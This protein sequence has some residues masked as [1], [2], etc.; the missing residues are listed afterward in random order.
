M[1]QLIFELGIRKDK[2]QGLDGS[3]NKDELNIE[4]NK[5]QNEERDEEQERL[6]LNL[7]NI[8][9]GADQIA[10]D[11]E[12]AKQLQRAQDDEIFGDADINEGG[13]GQRRAAAKQGNLMR[14]MNTITIDDEDDEYQD[15]DEDDDKRK[16]KQNKGQKKG[17]QTITPKKKKKQGVLSLVSKQQAQQQPQKKRG[18]KKKVIEDKLQ[19]ELDMRK[20]IK[21]DVNRKGK[22]GYVDD[23]LKEDHQQEQ[24]DIKD[25]TQDQIYKDAELAIQ[26]SQQLNQQETIQIDEQSNEEKGKGRNVGRGK[27]QTPNRNENVNKKKKKKKKRNKSDQFDILDDDEDIESFIDDREQDDSFNSTRVNV[28]SDDN[29][30]IVAV[31]EIAAVDQKEQEQ[32]EL[33]CEYNNKQQQKK[34][35]KVQHESEEEDY[36]YLNQGED[37]DEYEQDKKK[38]KKK[39]TQKDEKDG[40]GQRKLS[41]ARKKKKKKNEDDAFI[42]NDEVS[43][44]INY[45]DFDEQKRILKEQQG[46]QINNMSIFEDEVESI[47]DDDDQFGIPNPDLNLKLSKRCQMQLNLL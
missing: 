4:G 21:G 19:P 23:E 11:E 47:Q 37:D 33:A 14:L 5:Q 13:R 35:K 22:R 7:Y 46:S 45:V 8:S 18:P 10:N 3:L 40:Q 29:L 30:Q 25:N 32:I 26:I 36:D 41:Q 15:E 20:L 24:K 1:N 16:K 12:L 42:D 27:K 44:N 2:E 17:N 31:D 28:I 43:D 6:Q 9:I 34:Q 39:K 38:K